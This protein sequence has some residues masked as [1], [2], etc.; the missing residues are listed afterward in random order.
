MT[1]KQKRN[2]KPHLKSKRH[3]DT[4]KERVAMRDE[5]IEG[6]GE[7]NEVAFTKNTDNP[8]PGCH[9]LLRFNR[10]VKY[11][12]ARRVMKMACSCDLFKGL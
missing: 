1:I 6:T 5:A 7:L 8:R 4:T 11:K 3:L 9:F 12:I 2:V 10:P